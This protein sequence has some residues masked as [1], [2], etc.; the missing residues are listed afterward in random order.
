MMFWFADL[1]SH[2]YRPSSRR[3][4]AAVCAAIT[5]N[6]LAKPAT[7]LRCPAWPELSAAQTA[8]SALRLE[9]FT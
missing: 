9:G 3:A 4:L 5:S 1:S 2:V 7:E 8:A 6:H